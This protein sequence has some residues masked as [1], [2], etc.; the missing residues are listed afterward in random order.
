M[1]FTERF[2]PIGPPP[3]AREE[4]AARDARF[5][6]IEVRTGGTLSNQEL[7]DLSGRH[8]D[9]PDLLQDALSAE[10]QAALDQLAAAIAAY[11]ATPFDG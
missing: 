7:F 8:D 3:G 10:E 11:R 1:L 4:I 2:G 5:K 6:L 9:G